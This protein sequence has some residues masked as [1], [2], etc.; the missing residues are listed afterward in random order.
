VEAVEQLEVAS[1]VPPAS[2]AAGRKTALAALRAVD[3]TNTNRIQA[4]IGEEF[5]D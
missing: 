2:V 4:R 5:P 3:R 1:E